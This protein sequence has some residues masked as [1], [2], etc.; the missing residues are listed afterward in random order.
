MQ[1]RNA[2]PTENYPTIPIEDV[3]ESPIG[4]AKFQEPIF[5][6]GEFTG[7]YIEVE[8]SIYPM[9][10]VEKTTNRELVAVRFGQMNVVRFL[11][12]NLLYAVRM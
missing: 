2:H 7:Q 6:R 11:D 4:S 8:V 3:K 9:R 10:M 12:P 5:S 1:P